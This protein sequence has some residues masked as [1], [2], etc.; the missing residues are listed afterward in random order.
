MSCATQD[1]LVALG[2]SVAYFYSIFSV[3]ACMADATQRPCYDCPCDDPQ[4]FETAAMLITFI[5]LG[6]YLEASA[7]GKASEA[8][9]ALLQ[10]QPANALLVDCITDVDDAPR[11]VAVDTLNK[12]DV[13]KVLPGASVP[14]DC[15]VLRGQSV[16][17]QSMITGESVPIS[18]MEGDRII[19]GTLNGHGVL[20]GLVAAEGGSGTLAQIM[21]ANTPPTTQPPTHQHPP[22]TRRQ[23]VA[24]LSGVCARYV[25]RGPVLSPADASSL[26]C[27]NHSPRCGFPA[28]VDTALERARCGFPALVDTA[29][30]RAPDTALERELFHPR[31][32]RSSFQRRINERRAATP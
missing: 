21:Q 22:P 25:P 26:L 15:T 20:W 32:P 3:G 8:V 10:L 31:A 24:A 2:T 29:L 1:T 12:G 11:E 9:E 28:L 23:I 13:V 27:V 5:M 18:K 14:A 4:Q 30:E 16:V 19:G 7:K 17:N 6:K